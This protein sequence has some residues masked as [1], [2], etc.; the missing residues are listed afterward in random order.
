M[1]IY[2]GFKMFVFC[3]SMFVQ[4][5]NLVRLMGMLA[6]I[7]LYNDEESKGGCACYQGDCLSHQ[8]QVINQGL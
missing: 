6:K 2:K 1:S 8:V 3:K 7:M 5:L 4:V